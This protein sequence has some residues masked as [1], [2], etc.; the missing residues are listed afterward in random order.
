[1]IRLIVNLV[2]FEI[3]W[4]AAV[5]GVANGMLWLALLAVGVTVAINLALADDPKRT[6]LA[7]LAVV[8][9]GVGVDF[10][11]TRG[12]TFTF[13]GPTDHPTLTFLLWDAALWLNFAV[14]LPV[15]FKWLIGRPLL[16]AARDDGWRFADVTG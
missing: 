6:L 11:L 15:A 14:T 9:L 1:M 7:S 16:S 8:V 4:T 3:A 10:A 13:A 2:G 5:L 12:G